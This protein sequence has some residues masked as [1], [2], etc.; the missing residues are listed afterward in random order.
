MLSDIN[1][2]K[3]LE[4]SHVNHVNPGGLPLFI[5]LMVFSSFSS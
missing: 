2:N 5:D 3:V 4:V 1:Q